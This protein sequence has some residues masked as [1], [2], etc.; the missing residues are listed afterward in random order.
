MANDGVIPVNLVWDPKAT[1]K[2]TGSKGDW[3]EDLG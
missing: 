1:N 2:E 3:V